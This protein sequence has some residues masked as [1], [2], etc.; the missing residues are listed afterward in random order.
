M[1][2]IGTTQHNYREFYWQKQA[3]LSFSFGI[4]PVHRVFSAPWDCDYLLNSG[5]G[6]FV[7]APVNP[8]FIALLWCQL[9]SPCRIELCRCKVTICKHQRLLVSSFLH[10]LIFQRKIQSI[11]I[12]LKATEGFTLAISEISAAS[13]RSS[14]RL[15]ASNDDQVSPNI[16]YITVGR[17]LIH[18]ICL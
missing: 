7:R 2:T 13:E 8:C 5:A 18:N 4:A 12:E 11:L 3:L 15:S 9:S 10:H 17:A 14:R 16:Q 1:E 6:N